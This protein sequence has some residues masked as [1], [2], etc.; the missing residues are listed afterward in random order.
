[1]AAQQQAAALQNINAAIQPFLQQQLAAGANPLGPQPPPQPVDK[2]SKM[3]QKMPTELFSGLEPRLAPEFFEQ[4]TG[5]LDW[6]VIQG[7][8]LFPADWARALEIFEQLLK[9]PA[10]SWFHDLR[11]NHPNTVGNNVDKLRMLFLRKYNPWGSTPSEWDNHWDS[12]RYDIAK[13]EFAPFRQDVELLGEILGKNAAQILDKIKRSLPPLHRALTTGCADMTALEKQLQDLKPFSGSLS[14][15]GTGATD[16]KDTS[17]TDLLL[18]DA[19][20]EIRK[21]NELHTQVAAQQQEISAH[22]QVASVP[23]PEVLYHVPSEQ[24]V[25]P[26]PATETVPVQYFM[27]Q[28]PVP[29]KFTPTT[30]TVPYVTPGGKPIGQ[31]NM[32]LGRGQVNSYQPRGGGSFRG[33]GRGRGQ[34][35]N[36]GNRGNGSVQNN[37]YVPNQQHQDQGEYPFGRGYTLGLCRK[38]KFGDHDP[39]TCARTQTQMQ[40]INEH[41]HAFEST[42]QSQTNYPQDLR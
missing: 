28:V 42:A 17:I 27:A 14:M 33:R 7:H 16:K 30:Q 19:L 15:T 21:S 10:K 6:H 23:E 34:Q 40:A 11:V 22:V 35:N 36:Q 1:M 31:V 2:S 4:F 41:L 37:Q 3:M 39:R 5:F 24:A 20:K 8:F 26:Q 18:H 38:C 12:L 13:T 29:Q 32:P 25:V 9:G